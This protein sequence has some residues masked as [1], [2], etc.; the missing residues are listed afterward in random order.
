MLAQNT[1]QSM[2]NE[3]IMSSIK[4]TV[5]ASGYAIVTLNFQDYAQN[6]GTIK[7]NVPDMQKIQD[8]QSLIDNIRSSGYHITTINEL[9]NSFKP[10]AQWATSVYQWSQDK[11][12]SVDLLKSMAQQGT[13]DIGSNLTTI[14]SW[15]KHDAKLQTT[16]Q[17]SDDEFLNA[18]QYLVKIH[19]I[20]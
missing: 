4:D 18:I 11:I 5:H 17:I 19:A 14:P 1:N 10:Q 6:N 12:S 9:P 15:V 16:G 13:M 20:R 2:L 3:K 8:L 7:T